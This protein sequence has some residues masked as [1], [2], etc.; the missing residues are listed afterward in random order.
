M[1]NGKIYSNSKC[2]R[3]EEGVQSQIPEVYKRSSKCICYFSV[4]LT[5]SI[6]NERGFMN[7]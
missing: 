4:G 5:Y 2:L 7:C 3:L 6:I 1:W